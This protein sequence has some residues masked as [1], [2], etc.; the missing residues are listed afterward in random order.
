M[1]FTTDG[2][3]LWEMGQIPTRAGIINTWYAEIYSNQ[4]HSG[5]YSIKM[6]NTG[7]YTRVLPVA[8][9]DRYDSLWFRPDTGG[10]IILEDSD[11]NELISI[12][13]DGTYWDAYVGGGKV[14]DG[15]V[16]TSSRTWTHIQI[17][18]VIGDSGSIDTRIDGTPDISYSG[19]TKP[20]SATTVAKVKFVGHG[21]ANSYVDD[22]VF[23]SGGWPGDRRVEFKAVT[24]DIT[25]A[26]TPS[27]GSDNYACIDERPPDDNDY[28]SCTTDQ[29]DEYGVADFDATGKGIGSVTVIAR[30][31]KSDG[32]SDDKITLGMGDG[33]NNDD[34]SAESVLTSYEHHWYL[35][36]TAPDGG[37]W[38]DTDV[39]NLQIRLLGDIA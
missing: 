5:T 17:H 20:G 18:T 35:S 28:V 16:A 24:S 1:A 22:W 19:D 34:G 4:A 6:L 31:K 23:G 36:T 25:Q 14:A 15:S 27:T 12:R 10:D 26:W 11:G 33:V 32:G 21:G 38:T 13:W 9:S 39:D 2:I 7:N 3:G 8:R 37:A 29:T 30:V